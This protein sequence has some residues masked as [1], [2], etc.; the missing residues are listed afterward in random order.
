MLSNPLIAGSDALILLARILL[1]VLF[2]ITGWQKL[3][4]FSATTGYMSSIGAPVPA[5]STIVSIIMEF[6]V[7]ISLILGVLTRPL[8]LIF[9]LFTLVT[10]FVGHHY[11]T[12][13]GAAREENKINFYKNLSIMGGLLLLAVT[14]PGKYALMS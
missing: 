9:V 8:A 11:W 2:L 3:T 12:M 1:M 10:A 7:G 4:N 5:V 14:G 13:E 6:F